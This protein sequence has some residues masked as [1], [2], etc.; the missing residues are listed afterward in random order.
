M[1]MNS[2]EIYSYKGN[3]VNKAIHLNNRVYLATNKGVKV[4][5]ANWCGYTNQFV[6][7]P[8]GGFDTAAPIY[9]ECTEKEAEC[10]EAGVTGYPTTKINGEVYSGG[11]TLAGLADATGCQLPEVEGLATTSTEVDTSGCGA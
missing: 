8:L 9:V 7:G 1:T 3:E 6:E 4:Y 2:D 11:R 10:S 5:G